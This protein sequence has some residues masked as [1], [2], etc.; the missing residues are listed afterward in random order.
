MRCRAC[1]RTLEDEEY[2]PQCGS[3]VVDRDNSKASRPPESFR[4]SLQP[5]GS[6][7]EEVTLWAG[8]FSWK[9]LFRELVGCVVTTVVLIYAK[10]NVNDPGVQV[11]AIPGIGL[12][13]LGFGVWL[14]YQK[15]NVSY[16]LTSQR[17]IHK[18]GILYRRVNRIEAIDIDDVGYEQ[19]LVE[20]IIDVGRIYVDTSDVSHRRGLILNGINHPHD[21]CE[22]IDKARRDE[23]M[24]YG[25][26]V[27]AI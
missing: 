10:L 2:C 19:G 24:R 20:R 21:V 14:L 9:G 27:E 4:R 18:R 16:R 25:L 5:R 6:R 3:R 8:S 7:D 13:W 12:I 22:L 15:L 17:L 11:Y 23:R 26:H 1:G